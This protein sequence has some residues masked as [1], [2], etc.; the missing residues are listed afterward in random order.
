MNKSVLSFKDK[1]FGDKNFYKMTLTI[2]I[3]I[4][5]QNLLT[6]LVSM[7]DN[8]MVGQLGTNQ[9]S[10]VAIINQLFFVFNLLVLR[11]KISIYSSCWNVRS[12]TFFS[13]VFW[14]KESQWCS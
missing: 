8:I 11:S 2:A 14:T 6:N 10:G 1:Y 12:R 5:I 7:A 9:M 4:I 3:P 13:P